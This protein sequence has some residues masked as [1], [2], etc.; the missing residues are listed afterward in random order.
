M[1]SFAVTAYAAL[2]QTPKVEDALSGIFGSISLTAWI[3]LL[4]PQLIANYKAQSADG[5]SMGF[6]IIWLLGDVT[7]L[8]GAL[9]T[10]LAPTA[11]ALASYFCFA[12]LIL[13]SQCVYY[14]TRNARRN[15]RRRSSAAVTATGAAAAPTEH[16]PLLAPAN[17]RRRSSSAGLPGSHRRHAVHHESSLDPLRKMVTGE[18]ETPDSN[19]W[20]HNTLSILAVYLVGAAGW[21][22]SYKVGAWDSPDAEVGAP[23]EVEGVWESVGLGLGYISAVCYLCARIPQ[24]VKNYREKSCEGLALLFF[25][26]SL[27]GNFTYGASLVAF[28]QDKAYL[29]NALPWLLGSLGTIA[30][31]FI[32]FAQ[33]HLYTPRRGAKTSDQASVTVLGQ[34]MV[35]VNDAKIA[36]EL[37][38]KRSAK[39][40]SRPFQLFSGEMVGFG[41][42]LGLVPYNDRFR[43][44][45]TNIAKTIGTRGP[46][47]QYQQLQ[48]AESG[49][50]LLRILDKP[51]GLFDH[52]QKLAGSVIL[53]MTYGYNSEPFGSDYLV[54]A[55]A[56]V[57]HEFEKAVVPGAFMVDLFPWLRYL[58]EWFPGTGWKQTAKEWRAHLDAVIEKPFAFVKHQMAESKHDVD[59]SIL[60]QL[61]SDE[62]QT[63][64]DE[65]TAKWTAL[66]LYTGGTDTTVSSV[67]CFFLA[68]SV[69]PDVQRKAQAEI[70]E[71][72]GRERL[73]TFSDRPNLPY[74]GAVVKEVLRW[75]PVAPMSLPHAAS[76]DDTIEGYFIP[77]NALILTN[78]WHFTHDPDVYQSP[79]DFRP[80]RFLS[81]EGRTPETDP[82]KFV[83]GFGRRIC[84]GRILADDALFIT[85]AQAL[86]TLN[87]GK[88]VINALEE[89]S[90]TFRDA[91]LATRKLNLRY[92]WID[93]LCIIQDSEED[94]REQAALMTQVYSNAFINITAAYAR[95]GTHGCFVERDITD[96]KPIEVCVEWGPRPGAFHVV[97]L[98]SMEDDVDFSPL[99]QRAWVVQER[100][101]ARRNLHCCKSQL[102]WE[103]NEMKANE[104]FP[105]GLMLPIAIDG[106]WVGMASALDKQFTHEET[107]RKRL[108]ALKQAPVHIGFEYHHLWDDIVS[109]Y[110][111]CGLTFATDKLVALSGLA[112]RMHQFMK[113]RYLAG[114][115]EDHLS[116]QLLWE[117]HNDVQP[118]RKPEVYVAPSWSW[119][120][121]NGAVTKVAQVRFPDNRYWGIFA[122]G[123]RIGKADHFRNFS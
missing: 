15:A 82:Q 74:V 16:E 37:L 28:K 107:K 117:G 25:L 62:D 104:S 103:C 33:F 93:S 105:D 61:L 54:E 46:A 76:E 14:N 108:L 21:F 22:V 4:L 27:T 115:W 49:H 85:V 56:Q 9:F 71:V 47:S 7:N 30:E 68:M 109:R 26:L 19:P 52:I 119:A 90:K 18:D 6:L 55:I 98:N 42:M 31:D 81:T 65:F 53:K 99:H 123:R 75:H 34:T 1:A 70:D 87:I 118:L 102:F 66:S 12:D 114:L 111:P 89:M 60:G 97:N 11:V 92:I 2:S 48:E 120:S 51:D 113:C 72:I 110:S 94:W 122:G 57:T 59:S 101:L 5:L 58:P 50:L 13:I 91:L 112:L 67:A 80:E 41:N 23:S 83:F 78:I 29:L 32:I 64:E 79:E 44:H 116:Y 88:R 35:I 84:P 8:L 3:C 95:D 69:Y 77:K 10:H 24:I 63:A 86:S 17:N 100:L 39:Y 96:V 45:R 38:E 106:D 43:R 20:L 121:V 73:P 40:S 36:F